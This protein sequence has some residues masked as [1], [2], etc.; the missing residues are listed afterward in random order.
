MSKSLENSYEDK[1]IDYS[2]E[3]ESVFGTFEKSIKIFLDEVLNYSKEIVLSDNTEIILNVFNHQVSSN[4]EENHVV[5]I[6]V[7]EVKI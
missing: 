3:D 2:V 4:L 7:L 6:V 5:W 1:A